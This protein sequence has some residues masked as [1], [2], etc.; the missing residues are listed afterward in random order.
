[1]AYA[2]VLLFIVIYG[3]TNCR[4]QWP[5]GLR[6][7]S[8]AAR[9]LRSWVRVLPGHG[10]LSVVCVVC[11]LV[12]VSATNWSLV[13]EESFRLWRVVVCDQETSCDEEA[14]TRAGLQCQKKWCD[15]VYIYWT[16]IGL[17]PGGSSTSHIYTQT[18]HKIQRK[19]N[20]VTNYYWVCVS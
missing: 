15:V 12:E 1:M 10:C 18:I 19:E 8:T 3:I 11:C 7:R 17:T 9:L 16:A 14:I 6:R 5:R 2:S 20:G 4:S 13:Q